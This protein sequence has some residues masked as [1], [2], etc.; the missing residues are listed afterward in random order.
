MISNYHASFFRLNFESMD[1]NIKP[2]IEI[3]T[4]PFGGVMSKITKR[5]ED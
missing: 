4:R 3:I 1:M 2:V 5:E